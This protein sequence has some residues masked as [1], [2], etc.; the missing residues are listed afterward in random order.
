MGTAYV[1][2]TYRYFS[3]MR[4]A[5]YTATSGRPFAYPASMRTNAANRRFTIGLDVL[6]FHELTLSTYSQKMKELGSPI[7]M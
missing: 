6:G 5:S 1:S 3:I 2:I 4:E 7:I